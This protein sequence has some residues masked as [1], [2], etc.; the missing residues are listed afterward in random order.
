MK[1]RRSEVYRKQVLREPNI[2]TSR[3][4]TRKKKYSTF[5][6]QPYKEDTYYFS[7]ISEN[8]LHSFFF[9]LTLRYQSSRNKWH[10]GIWKETLKFWKVSLNVFCTE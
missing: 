5:V 1:N 4:H 2:T 6:E 3:G 9:S 8:C 10:I 7:A